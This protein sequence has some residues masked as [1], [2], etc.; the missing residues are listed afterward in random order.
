[1]SKRLTRFAT[2]FAATRFF[3]HSLMFEAKRQS[4]KRRLL[5]VHDAPI[6]ALQ[7]SGEMSDLLD[8]SGGGDEKRRNPGKFWQ[9]RASARSRGKI[10][11][12]SR[13]AVARCKACPGCRE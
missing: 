4:R 5:D 3:N 1:M 8:G 9:K 7:G 12:E 11:R 6:G 2:I 13:P 10:Q